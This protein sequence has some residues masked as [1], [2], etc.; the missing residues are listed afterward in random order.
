MATHSWV[1]G[2]KAG[3][4]EPVATTAQTQ[5][6]LYFPRQCVCI[7]PKPAADVMVQRRGMPSPNSKFSVPPS[8]VHLS[9]LISWCHEGSQ[10]Q[11]L[12]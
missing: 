4:L 12:S 3:V 11:A 9:E 8:T 7:W 2:G 10:D 6:R 5:S 1:G